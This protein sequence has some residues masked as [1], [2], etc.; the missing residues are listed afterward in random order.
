MTTMARPAAGSSFESMFPLGAVLITVVPLPPAMLDF[1][2]AVSLC[3]ALLIFMVALF[4]EKPLEFSSFPSLLLLVTLFRLTLSIATTRRILLHGGEGVDAAGHMVQ[5]FG[6]FAV[7]GNYVVGTVVFLILVV[8]NFIVITKG[9]E[10]ISEVA[11]RFTLDSM[12]GK[13]MAID[14]DLGAGLITEEIARE[15]RA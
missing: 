6:E 10:R 2:L 3:L 1:L 7:G 12:P 5:A 14:A 13:Q 11:A 9:S 15:R 8:V 4:V